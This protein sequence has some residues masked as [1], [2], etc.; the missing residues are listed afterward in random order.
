MGNEIILSTDITI[1]K[2]IE[3]NNIEEI[4]SITLGSQRSYITYS[5]NSVSMFINIQE[6]AS[7]VESAKNNFSYNLKKENLYVT[8][9]VNLIKKTEF[10]QLLI[11]LSEKSI[12]EAEYDKEIEE[13]PSKYIIETDYLN[14]LDDLSIIGEIVR[15]IGLSMQT[16]EVAE[17]FSIE[18][19]SLN[20]GL[21]ALSF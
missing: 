9:I 1:S 17:M 18:L 5:T 11:Q 3:L 12:T 21:T 4:S 2:A 14:S 20:N 7:Y 10:L 6:M 8:A 16:D 13:N 19:S 15:K